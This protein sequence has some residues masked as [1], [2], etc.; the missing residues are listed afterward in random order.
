ME[1]PIR[2]NRCAREPHLCSRYS[3]CA[4]HPIWAQA[5]AYLQHL[6]GSTTFAQLAEQGRQIRAAQAYNSAKAPALL[7][8]RS[9][10]PLP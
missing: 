9:P 7:A 8:L 6:L 10:V 1:G 2:L 4:I 5:Q 3:F